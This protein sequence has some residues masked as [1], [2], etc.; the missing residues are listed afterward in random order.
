MSFLSRP[1]CEVAP[2]LGARLLYAGESA[3][4]ERVVSVPARGVRRTVGVVGGSG[5]T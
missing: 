2:K 1:R 4:K 3:R 5:L